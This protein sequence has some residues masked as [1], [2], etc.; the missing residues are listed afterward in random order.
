MG[1]RG[2][3]PKELKFDDLPKELRYPIIKMMARY[4]IKDFS[5]AY[6]MAG[7]LL[8]SNSEEYKKSVQKEGLRLYRSS[9]FIE[10]NKAR[11]TI[12]RKAYDRGYYTGHKK[13]VGD[14]QIW[15]Y[16]SVCGDLVAIKPNSKAHKA[17]ITLMRAQGWGHDS[18]LKKQ[19]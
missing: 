13:G 12:E 11:A 15:I 16:C 1:K 3:P 6:D 2:R 7:M 9:H 18:C 8:D 19:S 14:N 10:L 4:K 5:Q 17:V